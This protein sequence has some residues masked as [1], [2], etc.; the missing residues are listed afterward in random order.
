MDHN[1]GK[2]EDMLNRFIA[3]FLVLSLTACSTVLRNVSSASNTS[4]HAV[5]VADE[6]GERASAEHDEKARPDTEAATHVLKW[7]AIGLLTVLV[8][9]LIA[10][11][12]S[13][14]QID[15]SGCRCGP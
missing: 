8:I 12:T 15:L 13:S 10:F 14:K 1:S 4:D 5:A 11:S 7:V 9:G 3:A 6:H 2:G